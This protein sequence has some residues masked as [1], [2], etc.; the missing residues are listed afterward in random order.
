MEIKFNH[1]DT[2]DIQ[3]VG[4]L[5]SVTSIDFSAAL[6]KEEFKEDK[7]VL[8]FAKLDYISSAGLRVLLALKKKLVPLNKELEIKNVNDVINEI[9]RVTGFD[10]VLTIVK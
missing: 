9:F 4:R 2:L 5:D 10:K 3:L 1:N 6:D 7:V 8:D